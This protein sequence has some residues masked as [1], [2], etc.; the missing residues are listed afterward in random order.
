MNDDELENMEMV[1]YR[2]D[3]EGFHY[4]F[5]HYSDFNEINDE[6]FHEL[7][8]KYL[9]VTNELEKYINEKIENLRNF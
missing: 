5:K 9:D 3:A 7:R 2:M 1:H 4:C 6:K 8:L